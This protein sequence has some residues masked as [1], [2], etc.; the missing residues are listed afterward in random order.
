VFSS[1]TLF[2]TV[3]SLEPGSS[4]TR[5]KLLAGQPLPSLVSVIVP[6]TVVVSCAV[7][8]V[9]ASMTALTN[10]PPAQVIAAAQVPVGSGVKPSDG[11][12]AT[13]IGTLTFA[14]FPAV[15][16]PSPSMMSIAAHAAIATAATTNVDA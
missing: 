15:V 7:V 14:A 6:V 2:V 3:C 11:T 4:P 13:L 8:P 12:N 9:G 10:S 5:M 1:T 16:E